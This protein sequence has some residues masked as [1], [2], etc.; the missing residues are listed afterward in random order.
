[1]QRLAHS[2][3]D[4]Y[5]RVCLS[6]A[7]T[8][9]L[10]EYLENS[11]EVEQV[12]SVLH[13]LSKRNFSILQKNDSLIPSVFSVLFKQPLAYYYDK[14]P[15]PK[16]PSFG[17]VFT[18]AMPYVYLAHFDLIQTEEGR[19]QLTEMGLHPDMLRISVGLEPVEDIIASFKLA[20]I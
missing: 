20:G 16:G 2:I 9:K 7:S 5:E 11:P 15:L 3:S 17:T 6:S 19:Q 1:M 8:R 4:Y 18:L 14:L 12:Y 10:I 13:P